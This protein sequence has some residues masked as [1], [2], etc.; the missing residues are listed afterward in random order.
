MTPKELAELNPALTLLEPRETYDKCIV[1]WAG[2]ARESYSL[3]YDVNKIIECLVEKDGMT[4]GKAYEF[5]NYNIIGA[6][7][8]ERTPI[9]LWPFEVEEYDPQTNNT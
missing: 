5:F 9:F 2:S 3:C 1:G 7:M 6:Y 8:G 4:E